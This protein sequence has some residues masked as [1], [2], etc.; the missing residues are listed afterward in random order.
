[1][2]GL[3]G[4]AMSQNAE[5]AFSGLCSAQNFYGCGRTTVDLAKQPIVITISVN[6]IQTQTVTL[7]TGRRLNVGITDPI[8]LQGLSNH[9][10]VAVHFVD[11]QDQQL[12]DANAALI[13]TNM[14]ID[15]QLVSDF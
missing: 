6:G 1:M 13:V 2:P 15:D 3:N 10:Q 8:L 11:Q 7:T 5:F 12:A 9:F 4:Y 14:V